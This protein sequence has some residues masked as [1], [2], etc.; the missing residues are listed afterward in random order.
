MVGLKETE[1]LQVSQ[2]PSWF[3]HRVQN[4]GVSRAKSMT[5]CSKNSKVIAPGLGQY[6]HL[7]YGVGTG[8]VMPGP[9]ADGQHR[10]IFHLF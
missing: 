7:L 10:A 9:C 3:T 5:Y 1:V 8:W 4:Q 2:S 6:S